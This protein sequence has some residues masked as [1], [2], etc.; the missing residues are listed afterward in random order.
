MS[1]VSGALNFRDVGGLPASGGVTRAGVLFRS[2]NLAGLDDA[3][4][5]ALVGLGIRRV[6]DLRA[7]DEVAVEPSRVG[8]L[9][10]ETIRIPLFLG[11][12][13]SF[14]VED[15]SLADVYRGLVDESAD[16]MVAVA[17]AVIA[18]APALVHCTVGKDR[19]GVAVAL[20]L[21]AVGV[22]HDAIVADYARTEAML[23]ARR[24]ARVLAY[25]RSVHP[26]ARHLEDLAT[27]SPAPVMHELL[28]D[29]RERFGSGAGYLVAHGLR[30]DEVDALAEI[31]IER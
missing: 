24:N 8:G 12:V 29:V 3:G 2:G 7:D 1:I 5:D 22:E 19:T 6:V 16:R 30:V 4:R 17:R 20:L 23:P 31:L 21:D 10:L 25:L 9:D 11:S 28:E 18:G 14:F 27:R 13:A 15:R 26:D